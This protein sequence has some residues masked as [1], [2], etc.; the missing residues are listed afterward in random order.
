MKLTASFHNLFIR[1]ILLFFFFTQNKP[2]LIEL[3]LGQNL[4]YCDQPRI[5]SLG[6]STVIDY[7]QRLI[8]P[9]CTLNKY[10]NYQQK[11]Y[12]QTVMDFT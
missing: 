5:W 8:T 10:G 9:I 4:V 1:H 12:L 3:L 6:L 7:L 11:M 2:T